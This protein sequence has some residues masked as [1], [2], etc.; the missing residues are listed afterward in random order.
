MQYSHDGKLLYKQAKSFTLWFEV[1]WGI[2]EM[3]CLWNSWPFF[4]NFWRV[5]FTEM[6]EKLDTTSCAE[7]KAPGEQKALEVR[8]LH[9]YG[10]Q[11]CMQSGILPTLMQT[12]NWQ[13]A[14]VLSLCCTLYRV[15]HKRPQKLSP[16]L[17]GYVLT[18]CTKEND[19]LIWADNSK[20]LAQS[21]ATSG[22]KILQH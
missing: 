13:E 4:L 9:C 17:K 8:I 20:C 19:L 7:T 10:S 6:A 16:I 18:V 22:L 5:L 21:H 15:P 3:F 12:G 1:V 14:G 2:I 11:T